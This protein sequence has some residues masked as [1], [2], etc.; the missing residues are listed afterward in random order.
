MDLNT[1]KAMERIARTDHTVISLG[2]GIPSDRLES[3]LQEA[4]IKAAVYGVADAYSDPQGLIELRSAVAHGTREEGMAYSTD[5]IIVT[6]GAIEAINVAVRSA[7]TSTKRKIIIPTPAYSAYFS[8]VALAGG[9]VVDLPTNRECNWRL[10]LDLLERMVGQDTAAILL[11]NPNNPTGT[12]YDKTTLQTVADIAKSAGIPLII[13]EVYRHMTFKKRFYTPAQEPE[14]KDTVIRI[15]SFSKDFNM[16]GW[17]AGYIQASQQRIPEL[18]SIHDNLVNCAPVV[19]QYVALAAQQN[20]Q[21]IYKNNL[22]KYVARREQ[23]T[24]WLDKCADYLDY[25]MPDAGYFF[26]PKLKSD[27]NTVLVANELAA[28]GVVVIPGSTFGAS[29]EGYLRLCFGRSESSIDGGMERVLS[30]FEA[31]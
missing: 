14:Y 18:V 19:S 8:L 4:A 9:E 24:G 16:T 29:G 31:Q 30:Y 2:Q 6:V 11:S 3:A 23:M 1:I 12:V 25:T 20:A 7:L 17:R 26:F 13:D 10:N 22:S 28:H 21:V 5:E 27:I 15:M